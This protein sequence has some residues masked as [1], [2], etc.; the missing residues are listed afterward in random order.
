[1]AAPKIGPPLIADGRAS[2]QRGGASALVLVSIVLAALLSGCTFPPDRAACEIDVDCPDDEVCYE[3]G[4][5]LP[6]V[7]ARQLGARVGEEC[8]HRA[9]TVM[10]CSFTC[11]MRFCDGPPDF[12][13]AELAVS[14]GPTVLLVRWQPPRD[15]TAPEDLVYR[16][17]SS[18]TSGGQDFTAPTLEQTGGTSAR[19][20]GLSP[21]TPYYVVVRVE[22]GF[23]QMEQNTREVRGVPGCVE[24][25][26]QIQPLL[27]GH[28]VSCHGEERAERGLRLD[29]LAAVRAGTPGRPLVV[30]CRS[31][32]SRIVAR[33]GDPPPLDLRGPHGGLAPEEVDL[34]R[35][36]IDD[37]A[38]EACPIDRAVCAD[39]VPPTFAGVTS[40]TAVDATTVEVCWVAGADD[41]SPVAELVYD[42]Y[43]APLDLDRPP[44]VV[45]EPGAT[46]VS[47]RGRIPDADDCW[48]VRARDR[49][50]NADT[51]TIESC[52]TMPAAACLEY[53]DV[54]Q[55]LFD[56]RCIHCHGGETQPVRLDLTSY[57][58]MRVGGASGPIVVACD[59][60][61]SLLLATL[62]EDPPRDVRMPGD[63]PPY[64]TD[65]QIAAIRRWLIEGARATCSEPDPC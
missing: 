26:T 61:A 60:D 42:V 51:N 14:D 41:R 63:G 47:V 43:V 52:L 53:Q 58:A 62:G 18:T 13:G 16:V 9:G 57:D 50:G 56:A 25:A 30:P 48:T 38:Q 45:S 54:I 39:D 19:L 33:V 2:W 34:L 32:L 10:R 40:A 65:A 44:T 22:D 4:L 59:P 37:G 15:Q 17:Y 36:W 11:L 6:A 23:G 31:E 46:C 64:L 5:C 24:Y 29:T 49:S 27:E 8:S 1:M 20:E 35:A 55:P 28:C 12:E 7:A 21:E 3:D